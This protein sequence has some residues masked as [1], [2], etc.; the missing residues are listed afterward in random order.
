V[1]KQRR[2]LKRQLNRRCYRA[3]SRPHENIAKQEHR[4]QKQWI[5]EAAPRGHCREGGKER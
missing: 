4:G 5:S 2:R 1:G 3:E